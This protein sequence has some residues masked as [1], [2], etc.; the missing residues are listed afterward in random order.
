MATDGEGA[1]NKT[2]TDDLIYLAHGRDDILRGEGL[3][4]QLEED[5]HQ[6]LLFHIP[7]EGYSSEMVTGLPTGL[8]EFLQPMISAG[9]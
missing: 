9:R 5:P 3:E 6:E 7:S 4:V 1:V 2:L 8:Q